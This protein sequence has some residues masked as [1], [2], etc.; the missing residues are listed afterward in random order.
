MVPLTLR[1]F[2]AISSKVL[3]HLFLQMGRE[4]APEELEAMITLVDMKEMGSVTYEDFAAIFGNPAEA[5]RQVNSEAV[6]A[7]ARG[8]AR[9]EGRVP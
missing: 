3:R 4:V 8:E 9:P 6:K 2:E 1:L 5:L 7:A